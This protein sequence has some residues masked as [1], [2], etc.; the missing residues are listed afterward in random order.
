MGREH[1]QAVPDIKS[2][3]AR[4]SSVLQGRSGADGWVKQIDTAHTFSV[5]HVEPRAETRKNVVMHDVF[6]SE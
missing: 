4:V 5:L 6:R 1:E 2:H 3:A